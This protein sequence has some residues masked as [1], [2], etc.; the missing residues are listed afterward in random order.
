MPAAAAPDCCDGYYDDGAC[1]VFAC[2]FFSSLS[3]QIPPREVCA[4]VAS[5]WID[6]R[7]RLDLR[8]VV[9]QA[10][11]PRFEEAALLVNRREVPPLLIFDLACRVVES[12]LSWPLAGFFITGSNIR[13]NSW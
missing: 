5:P 10:C 6:Q 4:C 1:D 11:C 13:S 9:G 12:P 3:G 7:C 2:A 8:P